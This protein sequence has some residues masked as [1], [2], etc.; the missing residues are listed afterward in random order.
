ML[1]PLPSQQPPRIGFGARS[2]SLPGRTAGRVE[3][4]FGWMEGNRTRQMLVE[5]FMGFG[6]LRTVLDSLRGFFYGSGSLNILAGMERLLREGFSILTDNVLGGVFAWG[7]GKR[8]DKRKGAFSN[9]WTDYPTIELFQKLAAKSANREVFLEKLADRISPQA[10]AELVQHFNTA[11]NSPS[12][13]TKK[14]WGLLK[15]EVPE[16][17]LQKRTQMAAAVAR[18]LGQE[19]LEVNSFELPNL[20]DD[21]RLFGQQMRKLTAESPGKSWQSLAKATLAATRKIK[22]YKLMGVALSVLATLAVPFVIA[23]NTR[24]KF[25]V[26]YYPGDIGLKGQ[27]QQKSAVGV[28]KTP[29]IFAHNRT[30]SAFAAARQQSGKVPRNRYY[31]LEQWQQGKKLPM[32]ATIIPVLFGFFFNTKTYRLMNPFK[33]GAMKKLYDFSK[34]APFTTQQQMA[35]AF[36]LLIS[37]RLLCSRSDNEYRERWI[38]SGLGWVVWIMATP[39][40]KNILARYVLDPLK[41]TRLMKTVQAEGWNG[42]MKTVQVLRER[43]EIEHLLQDSLLRNRKIGAEA[44]EQIVRKTLT[45]HKWLGMGSTMATM[46][47]LGI[48]EPLIGIFWSK[49]NAAKKLAVASQTLPVAQP[50]MVFNLR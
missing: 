36:A 44:A 2:A 21:V 40:L 32:L 35:S 8:L 22:N 19:S 15:R 3:K 49:H 29:A 41:G 33:F 23:R 42:Q 13:P 31:V 24:K 1:S 5:D 10:K 26:D 17:S 34:S 28:A 12:T 27:F 7:M 30:F 20:L 46:L 37:S 50:Q 4:A 16:L 18:K 25:G 43:A 38:D 6:V 14:L 47:I 9:G 11:W 45:S 39:F 48:V